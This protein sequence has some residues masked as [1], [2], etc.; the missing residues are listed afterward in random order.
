[1][2]NALMFVNKAM[3]FHSYSFT[4]SFLIQTLLLVHSGWPWHCVKS[5]R[6]R[7]FSGPHFAR[8]FQ[9]LDW[10]RRDN[11]CLSVFSPNARKCGKNGGQNNSEYGHFLHS[12]D[13]YLYLLFI[14]CLQ[15]PIWNFALGTLCRNNSISSQ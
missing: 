11:P 5:V 3:M 15:Q 13:K 6:I 7:S 14:Y 10:I 8:I 9:R 4:V 12:L 1:M 2:K